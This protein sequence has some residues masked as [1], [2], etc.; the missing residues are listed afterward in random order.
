M[1]RSRSTTSSLRSG[2]STRWPSKVRTNWTGRAKG[3]I[4]TVKDYLH[5]LFQP[6]CH[7]HVLRIEVGRLERLLDVREQERLQYVANS[8]RLS[9]FKLSRSAPQSFNLLPPL[10]PKANT[11]YS[12]TRQGDQ[13]AIQYWDGVIPGTLCLMHVNSVYWAQEG[14][15]IRDALRLGPND[16]IPTSR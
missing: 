8:K 12:C 3:V 2:I 16:P 9:G 7:C 11:V 15:N 14:D 13:Y 5:A 4:Q 10:Y 1:L 6:E